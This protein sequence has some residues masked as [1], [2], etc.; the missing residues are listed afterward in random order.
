MSLDAILPMIISLAEPAL[1][2]LDF[3]TPLIATTLTTDQSTAFGSDDTRIIT[4]ANW[5]SQMA[6]VGV[7]SS[8]DAYRMALALFG[9]SPKPTQAVWGNRATAVAQVSTIS[10]PATPSAVNYTV[11]INGV[12]IGPVAG[13]GLTQTQLRDALDTAIDASTEASR[14]TATVGSGT[15][16]VTS[17]EAGVPFSISVTGTGMSVA[18]T[19]PSVGLVE[20]VATFL[21]EN[22]FY[23][24]LEASRS[25]EALY[26]LALVIETYNGE[27]GVRPL[28]LLGQTLD[29]LAQSTSS[30]TDLMSRLS[31][32]NLVRTAMVWNDDSD[33]MVDAAL[34]GRVLPT[35]PGSNTWANQVLAGVSGFVPTNDTRLRA[36]RYTWL[37]SFTAAGFSMTQGARTARN[38][39]IDLVLGRDWLRNFLQIKLAMLVRDNPKVPYT[40]DG[41]NDCAD[42]LR[43]GLVEASRAPYNFLDED[44]IAITVPSVSSQSSTDRSNRNFPGVNWS[45]RAQGAIES[46]PIEGIITP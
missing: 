35:K 43:Q 31:A 29:P 10:I 9:Q 41:A 5:Q 6:D 26:Q 37:E 21:L 34:A 14:V 24:V 33:E 39:P 16:V 18:L 20:D 40:R 3:G 7:S 46:L 32:L 38:Y 2:T 45:A 15:V 44:T 17:D 27:G 1:G 19:T 23:M 28:M 25:I 8:E 22:S 13:S 11:V 42:T 30:P 4:P 36:K 12:T